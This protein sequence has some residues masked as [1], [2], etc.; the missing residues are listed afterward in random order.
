MGRFER[1]PRRHAA[2][3]IRTSNE[4]ICISLRNLRP[5]SMAPDLGAQWLVAF[6]AR[7]PD[8]LTM[9]PPTPRSL[10]C[11]L[12]LSAAIV[13]GGCGD[14]ATSDGGAGGINADGGTDVLSE[15]TSDTSGEDAPEASPDATEEDGAAGDA[16]VDATLDT[17][18]LQQMLAEALPDA[19][20]GVDG[21]SLVVHDAQDRRVIELTVG[22]FATDRRVPVASAS[23]LVTGLVLLRLVEEGTLHMTDTPG[24]VLGWTG[25][26]AANA[27]LDHLGA[28]VSGISPD[29][30]CIYRPMVTLQQCAAEIG[31]LDPLAA[32]GERFDYGGTHQAVAAAMAEVVTGEAWAALFDAK[33]KT[34]LGLDSP[35]LRYVTLPKQATGEQNPLVAGGLLA[36]ADEYMSMLAV[37]FHQG[38]VDGES[39]ISPSVIE[40]FG[41]N[42]YTGAV[43]GETPMG[44]IGLDFHYGWSSWLNCAGAVAS[45]E[46]VSSPGAYGFSPWVDWENGYYAV[47]A[48]ESDEPGAGS[49]FSAPLMEAVRAEI[50]GL[51]GP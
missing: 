2:T 15:A 1:T 23:K 44:A 26:T 34:P 27:T 20:A 41:E 25:T 28:F 22:D 12:T 49:E 30:L 4:T 39:W 21:I 32:P 17:A 31:A 50:E 29:A 36:T 47:L 9:R 46:V 35:D 42:L 13:A 33:L 43:I 24:E 5:T 37:L 45:C 40:R 8:D 48:M 38:K 14:D 7:L 16:S 6:R 11:L 3:H 10:S 19:P 18:K 51:L